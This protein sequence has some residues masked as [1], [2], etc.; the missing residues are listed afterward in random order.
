[1]KPALEHVHPSLIHLRLLLP[2]KLC[3]DS[4]SDNEVA[5]LSTDE[6]VDLNRMVWNR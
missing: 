5:R 4:R 1:M 2:A 3:L 6:A